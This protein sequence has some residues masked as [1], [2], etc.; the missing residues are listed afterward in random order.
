[1]SN[2]INPNAVSPEQ[3]AANRA[4]AAKSTGPTSPEGKARSAQ[5]AR[6][7]GFAAASYTAVGLE[8]AQDL[9]NLT[10]DAVDFY[11]PGNSQEQFAVE[12]IALAQLAVLRA[13]RFEAA[14]LS[15]SLGQ[16][17]PD[18][19]AP[20]PVAQRI[21]ANSNALSLSIRYSAHAERQYRRAVEDFV[22]LR[23]LCEDSPNEPEPR[24][25]ASG[26]TNPRT[27]KPSDNEMFEYLD[28]LL[29]PPRMPR[30]P[31]GPP[32]NAPGPAT[33]L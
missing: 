25:A 26:Q 30:P 18:P 22:R 23:S 5:N 7:H 15:A 19:V 10:D 24:P 27:R 2:P 4:N 33:R 12:R 13:A 6:K 11:Q 16:A 9:A 1:M 3:L 21:A 32:K 20:N 31:F 29:A 28:R 8:D 17:A 14:I